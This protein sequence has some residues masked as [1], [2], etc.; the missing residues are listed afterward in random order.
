MAPRRVPLG[1]AAPLAAAAALAPALAAEGCAQNHDRLA[2]EPDAGT[3]TPSGGAGGTTSSST[4]SGQGGAGGEIVEPTGPTELTVVAGV[5]DSAAVRLCFLPYPSVASSATPWPADPAG[6][7]YAHGAVVAPLAD[8]VPASGDVALWVL[9]GDLGAVGG[10]DC[11]ALVAAGSVGGLR[12]G[13]VGVL[14]A[15]VFASGKSL[16]FVPSGCLGGA[17][18]TDAFET[19]VCGPSYTPAYG[20]LN[21]LGA[22]MSRLTDPDKV[23]LQVAHASLGTVTPSLEVRLTPGVANAGPMTIATQWTFGAVD[24]YPPFAKL[25]KAGLGTVT[26]AKLALQQ[27]GQ[28]TPLAERTFAD[29]LALGDVPLAAIE[30]GAGLVFVAVGPAPNVGAGPWWQGFELTLV[31]AEPTP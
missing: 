17:D 27:Q 15:S 19:Y 3:T 25:A 24:P 13:L 23:S 5:V 20:S 1:L 16:L 12:V 22:S 31:R 7:A 28:P 6:L 30:D 11:D 2:S 4:T 18:H 14:P 26:E 9:G 10:A 8:V 21:L 29:A